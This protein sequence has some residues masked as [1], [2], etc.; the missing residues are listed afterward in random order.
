M[1]KQ[2][3]APASPSPSPAVDDEDDENDVDGGSTDE[4]IL[5][6]SNRRFKLSE[7]AEIEM[8]IQEL[9]DKK[10]YAGEQWDPKIAEQ[11]KAKDRPMV[12]INRLPQQVRQVTNDQ[13]QNRPAI[14]VNPVD[15]KA[16][17]ETAKVNQGLIRHIEYNSNADLAYD[18]AFE[19]AGVCGRGY[20]RVLTDFCDPMS[21][22]QEIK[23]GM[24]PNHF[25]VRLD[26]TSTQPDG[27]DANWGFIFE[28]VSNEDYR[29]EFPDSTISKGGEAI[30]DSVET[31]MPGWAKN[32]T[33]RVAEYFYKT[34][35][36]ATI[37]LMSD[38]SVFL[39][40]KLKG[41]KL[42]PGI[43]VKKERKTVLPAIQWV[44]R[45][46]A[47]ILDKKDWAGQWI[48]IIQVIGQRSDI[49]G[50]KI[51]EGIVRNA[52]DS[53]RI[54]NYMKSSMIETIAL[55]P[56]APYIGAAGQF[57]GHPEWETANTENH[58]HL[59]YEQVDLNGRP[60]PPPAR[61]VYEPPI[62]AMNIV[63]NEAGEDIKAT[64]GIYDP[65]L[66][67]QRGEES[68]RAINARNHQAQTSNF[69]L[70]DNL[71]RSIRHTGRICLELIP[72][73]Y[74][75]P[76]KLRILGEDG[77]P[78]MVQVNQEYEEG[79][80]TK[81]H[82]LGQGKYDCTV[83]TGPSYQTKRQEAAAS[84]A[85]LSR[86][87]PKLMEVAGDLMVSQM[88]WPMSKEVSERLKKTLPP[89]MAE[90][91]DKNQP[92][93]PPEIHQKM[94]Q[95][96]QMIAQLTQHLD[97]KTK[98]VEGKTLEL[99]SRE[100]IA[101]MQAKANVEIELAKLS[102]RSAESLLGH[103]I[104]ALKHRLDLLGENEPVENEIEPSS[105][106]TALAPGNQQTPP[107]GGPSPGSLMGG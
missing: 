106:Q 41:A 82:M 107:T 35:K 22:D 37:C 103:E 56:K 33:V 104:D 14:Q 84:M 15:D 58:S 13:R 93:L 6:I 16:T 12:T 68:G 69:H 76:A 44:K 17:V 67:N 90:S 47:Q 91:D 42:P 21:F 43:T 48:P 36:P 92:Q 4:E 99:E 65:T 32:K 96:D 30:F 45:D 89:G 2:A 73:V 63:M 95:M 10:F 59:E 61:N 88:D 53:Q 74:D 20:W 54:Y 77:V 71:T 38:G 26:P 64:T 80:E 60:A 29:A 79:G 3:P 27:S 94:Q 23:I 101:A 62:Q 75:T 7:E 28:D 9:D 34:F 49:D 5:E 98:L 78:K 100:R 11:R 87:Y 85:D 51:I 50:K 31:K 55:A 52:K 40:E 105:G 24:I 81:S 102:A 97:Q 46:G 18:T 66:G 1:A 57:E 86:A 19:S 39:K 72:V 8:R 70:I 83:S 25:M